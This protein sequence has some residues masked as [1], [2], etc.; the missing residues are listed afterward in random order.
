MAKINGTN[1]AAKIVPFTTEDQFATH[2]AQYGR[3]GWHEVATIQDRDAITEDRREAG[4]AVYVLETEGV[5]ILDE[6]LTTWNQLESGKVDDVQVNGTSVVQNKIA[7]VTVPTKVSDLTND[8]DFQTGTEVETSIATHNSDAE[9]HPDIR[10]EISSLNEWT[11]EQYT[12]TTTNFVVGNT[13]TVEEAFQRTASLFAG[14]QGEIDDIEAVIPAQATAQNQLADK[15]FV[16][17]TIAT[18]SANFRG[19]WATW[20]DVP[21]Q[22][23]EYPE[24]YVGNRTPTNN[25]YMVVDDTT[26][27]G[28]EYQGSW[29]F[30]YV[31]TWATDGKNGWN[32]VYQIGTAF[33]QEQQAAIDSGITANM[34]DNY[35]N[36]TSTANTAYNK[37]ITAVETDKRDI[38]NSANKVYATDNLGA[39]KNDLVYDKSATAETIAQRG[40]NGVLKVG[41]PVD[42]ADAT[43]KQ[44]VDTVSGNK[45]DKTSRINGAPLSNATSNFYGVSTSAATDVEKTVSIPSITTLDV[46]TVI[47][48]QPT[49]TSTV[50][51]STL[52]LNDFLAYP[53]RYNNAAVSTSTD[54]VVWNLNYISIF[55]FDGTYWQFAGH[56][57]DSNTTY[58]INYTIDAGRYKAG[59]GTYAVTR[60]S[61]LMEKADGT[62]EKIT[63]TN[64]NY[65]TG[66]T[67]NVNTNG[68]RLNHIRYY[69]TTAAVANGA[70]IATNT[71]QNKAASVNLSYSANCGTAPGWAIGDYIY[72][73]GTIGADGLF[74][75]DTTQWWSN[76][77]PNTNDGKLYIRLGIA[78]TATD[79]TMSFFDD[80]PIYYHDGTKICVYLEAD[81]KQDKLVS[82]TNIKTINN[83]SL[84]GAGNFSLSE[85]LAVL[86]EP[87][88]A[89]DS[90]IVQ[91]IGETI[92]TKHEFVRGTQGERTGTLNGY[93]S[94]TSILRTKLASID[95]ELGIDCDRLKFV[96]VSNSSGYYYDVYACEGETETLY[97]QN[98]NVT[99]TYGIRIGVVSS[100][101]VGTYIYFDIIYDDEY[102]YSGNFYKCFKKIVVGEKPS[103]MYV[104]IANLDLVNSKIA[105]ANETFGI[106]TAKLKFV[107]TMTGNNQ[108]TVYAVEG[109]DTEHLM[110]ADINV[111][112][113]P[114]TFGVQIAQTG[115]WTVGLYTE[116]E[117]QYYWNEVL[118]LAHLSD[119]ELKDLEDGQALI[120]NASTDKWVNGN[121]GVS[122]TYDATTKTITFA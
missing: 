59:I 7:N 73:V 31:G 52:K 60:Y 103:V 37:R 97:E 111:S 94:D 74:Y 117:Y 20:S 70:L 19:N 113:L 67:K 80:R 75:L 114:S 105:E 14:Q 33:T 32:P 22:A 83:E 21:T 96:V 102:N 44:Y 65:S 100:S 69:N 38:I 87:T 104:S 15:S 2:E 62:W 55:L 50:A 92:R 85:Q 88:S 28:S 56:G 27:Y 13:Y 63:A 39:N 47:F 29:R 95:S 61:L 109:D 76:A 110:Q 54:S 106:T 89:D 4:M 68:F 58:T 24:D 90:R 6:D 45:A 81:N 5:Y 3:G 121:G 46:G 40:T 79:A 119:V 34:V 53:M 18:N 72:L 108:F 84:L 82:G 118:E 115:N 48:V 16:N 86:P 35:V 78:L 10:A 91:Y 41:T 66:T 42:N 101:D 57:L 122:A 1:V 116:L 26:G 77:L 11:T 8:S 9:A 120:Y 23:S 71:L 107:L 30:I 17:A 49:V 93:V 64:A 112:N 43:T 98:T 99:S 36:P 51:S 25:D 12:P